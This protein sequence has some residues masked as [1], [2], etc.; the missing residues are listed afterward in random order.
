VVDG[1]TGAE[2]VQAAVARLETAIAAEPLFV[3]AALEVHPDADLSVFR[4]R[5]AGDPRSEEAMAA[6][7]RLRQELIPQAFEGAPAAALVTGKTATLVDVKHVNDTYTPIVIAFILALSFIL[8]MVAFRSIVVP[9]KAILMNLLS[10]A[11]AYGMLVLVFQKG[12]GASLLG[13]Q[14]VDVI[15]TGLPIFLFTVLFGLSMDYHVFLLSRVRER[16]LKTGDNA[17][18]VEYGLRSTG[19][20]ITGAA[21]IMVAVFG[22]FALG[23]MVPLQQMGFGLAVAVLIDA[24]IVRSILVPASMRLLGT[25]NW[26]LPNVLRWLPDLRIESVEH[27]TA[28]SSAD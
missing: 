26:Y 15:Q 18:A 27:A 3:G 6:V 9:I 12:F 8:L 17:E 14:Q 4:T 1:P 25:W 13:F 23:D 19:R 16:S 22:G 2:A 20:L 28:A 10:V 24:T 21:M 5:L 11:A 7:V